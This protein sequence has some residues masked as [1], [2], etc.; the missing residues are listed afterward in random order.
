MV[1]IRKA[2][3]DILKTVCRPFNFEDPVSDPHLL[4][5]TLA[6]AMVAHRGLGMAAPQIGIDTRVFVMKTDLGWRA[7]FNPVVLQSRG[8]D[9]K[10]EGCLSFPGMQVAV[11]RPRSVKATW[12][13]QI[14]TSHMMELDRMQARIFQH[15]LDH[16][17][18]VTIADSLT[19]AQ[20]VRARLAA[21]RHHPGR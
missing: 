7:C 15:E 21:A 16:L 18:G 6:D 8:A 5:Q 4:A 13:D 17:N 11:A 9:S 3:D 20:A 19:P 12:Q 2:G 10:M 1:A 14:G